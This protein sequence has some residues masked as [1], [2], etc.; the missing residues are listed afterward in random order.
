MERARAARRKRRSMAPRSARCGHG[1][2]KRKTRRSGRDDEGLGEQLLVTSHHGA[3]EEE[4]GMAAAVVGL[5]ATVGFARRSFRH[6]SPRRC[7][8]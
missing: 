2:R 4:P 7:W 1:E 3:E 8:S 6:S 5:V